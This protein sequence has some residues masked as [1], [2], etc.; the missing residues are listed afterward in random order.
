MSTPPLEQGTY[1]ISPTGGRLFA[2]TRADG[3]ENVVRLLTPRDNVNW[4]L[5]PTQNP[6]QYL[7]RLL[8]HA[9]PGSD[10]YVYATTPPPN[11]A[12]EHGLA[13]HVLARDQKQQWKIV[14]HDKGYIIRTPS[15][16]PEARWWFVE[17]PTKMYEPAIAFPA[18]HD[19]LPRSTLWNI[20]SV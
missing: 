16:E 5:M 9:P 20:Q 17:D 1:R 14:P 2:G 11:L 3:Y 4:E 13:D 15:D 8:P 12:A 7:L 6:G 18:G 10:S 19:T